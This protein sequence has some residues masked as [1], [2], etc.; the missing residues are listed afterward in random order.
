[1]IVTKL[2]LMTAQELALQRAG[3]FQF[4]ADA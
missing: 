3:K 2:V 4:R 1:M